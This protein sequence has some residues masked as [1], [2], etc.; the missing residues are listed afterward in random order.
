MY[1]LLLEE[2]S[3]AARVRGHC[4][5]GLNWPSCLGRLLNRILYSTSTNTSPGPVK[6]LTRSYQQNSQ[7]TG[8]RLP[9]VVPR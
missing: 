7:R 6:V 2:R 1:H 4:V 9:V 8:S 5:L 3:D